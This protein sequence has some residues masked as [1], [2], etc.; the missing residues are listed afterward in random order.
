MNGAEIRP[1]GQKFTVINYEGY[2]LYRKDYATDVVP[3]LISRGFTKDTTF[4]P[5]DYSSS[6]DYLSPRLEERY[7]KQYTPTEISLRK[8]KCVAKCVAC[9]ILLC[10]PFL[11]KATRDQ[12]K[13]DWSKK[14]ESCY[15]GSTYLLYAFNQNY[16]KKT[17]PSTNPIGC[18]WRTNRYDLNLLA[19]SLAPCTNEL[20]IALSSDPQTSRRTYIKNIQENLINSKSEAGSQEQ[21]AEV[22]NSL[23]KIGVTRIEMFDTLVRLRFYAFADRL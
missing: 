3:N 10:F 6:K 14:K 7:I 17:V 1:T 19:L 2:T 12:L 20:L 8:W 21:S 13:A 4:T 9:V 15:V 18:D 22:I 11:F 23:Q 5:P 16:S